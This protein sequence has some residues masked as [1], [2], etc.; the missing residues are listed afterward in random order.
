[1]RAFPI[2]TTRLSSLS[3]QPDEVCAVELDPC[4]Y[5]DCRGKKHYSLCSMVAMVD[6]LEIK[7]DTGSCTMIRQMM[8]NEDDAWGQDW[9]SPD[10]AA[11]EWARKHNCQRVTVPGGI[12]P[13]TPEGIVAV[14]DFRMSG[15]SWYMVPEDAEPLLAEGVKWHCLG[16]EE[17]DGKEDP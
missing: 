10:Q 12:P 9:I 4:E 7:G 14:P 2:D 11:R 5:L 13:L 8:S 17:T 3:V 6:R 1:M 15:T 16:A